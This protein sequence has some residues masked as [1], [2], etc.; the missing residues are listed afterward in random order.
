MCFWRR[1]AARMIVTGRRIS[2]KPSCSP[3]WQRS[4]SAAGVCTR[5][6]RSR[7][8]AS[9]RSSEHWRTWVAG[10]STDATR[11]RVTAGGWRCRV[12]TSLHPRKKSS[13]RWLPTR[14][15]ERRKPDQNS[16]FGAA[17]AVPQ[18]RR[19]AHI[20]CYVYVGNEQQDQN[21]YVYSR[22]ISIQGFSGL[23][24]FW[25]APL[26]QETSSPEVQQSTCRVLVCCS[27]R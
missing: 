15:Y 1:T 11:A 21:L 9:P 14:D 27:A 6:P 23:L 13:W 24:V 3:I 2:A 22:P 8:T 16:V 20:I 17:D 7:A 5:K 25:S 10:T 18:A 4:P 26:R 12:W 19:A